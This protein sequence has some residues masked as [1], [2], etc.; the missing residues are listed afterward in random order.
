MPKF[1]ACE[2]HLI[3]ILFYLSLSTHYCCKIYFRQTYIR[4]RLRQKQTAII[5]SCSSS[6]ILCAIWFCA[7]HTKSWIPSLQTQW[8]NPCGYTGLLPASYLAVAMTE[9]LTAIVFARGC[10]ARSKDGE[11]RNDNEKQCTKLPRAKYKR[12]QFKRSR[13]PP[14]NPPGEAIHTGT[15][16]CFV[17]LR[18]SQRLIKI[19]LTRRWRI[20]RQGIYINRKILV[21]EQFYWYTCPAGK[22]PVSS[23][24][25]FA[26]L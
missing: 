16:D 9:S 19:T 8:S 10:E 4:L 7:L 21:P 11:G 26:L 25:L 5:F 24:V 3:Y 13:T 15:P 17:L 22:I 14:A 23:F 12:V 6:F 1:F 2:K 18:T 20:A